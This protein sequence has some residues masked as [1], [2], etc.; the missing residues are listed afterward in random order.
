MDRSIVADDLRA[1]FERWAAFVRKREFES[2]KPMFSPNVIGFGTRMHVVSGLDRLEALQWRN[3]W[4]TIKGF[5]FLT[6]ELHAD[7]SNDGSIAWA[8][9]PWVSIGFHEDGSSFDR[10]G[11]ATVIFTPGGDPTLTPGG[12]LAVHTHISLAPG[13]PQRSY[14]DP[15]ER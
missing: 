9:V 14:G 2:A 7:V 11:R 13:T 12:W 5:Q 3:V 10:P 1:W 15:S 8:V 4:P 6:D